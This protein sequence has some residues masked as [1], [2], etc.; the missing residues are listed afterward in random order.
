MSTVDRWR[1]SVD[2]GAVSP[3]AATAISKGRQGDALYA[4]ISES[5]SISPNIRPSG[6]FIGGKILK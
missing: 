4:A 2:S 5:W 3:L 1:N 6:A